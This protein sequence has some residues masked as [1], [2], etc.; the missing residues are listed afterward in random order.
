MA[1]QASKVFNDNL[2]YQERIIEGL[3]VTVMGLLVVFAVLIILMLVLKAMEYIFYT[4]KQKKSHAGMPAKQE[5]EPKPTAIS[6]DIND[7]ELI[8]VLTA[9]V[10]ASLNT[11][12]YHLNIKSYKEVNGTASAW[13]RKS[14]QDL[15]DNKL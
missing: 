7:D 3:K 12:T 2:T 10:A 4:S 14:R 15:I 11:S 5:T 13:N 8:A 1:E 9:A 6:E